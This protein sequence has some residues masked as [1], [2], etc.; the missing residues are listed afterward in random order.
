MG[1]NVKRDKSEAIKAAMAIEGLMTE[2]E[3]G[4][5]ADMLPDRPHLRVFETGAWLGRSATLWH[6]LGAQVYTIDDWSGV[7][8]VPPPFENNY[9]ERFLANVSG[10]ITPIC[11]NSNTHFDLLLTTVRLLFSVRKADLVFIDGDHS[12]EGVMHDIALAQAAANEYTVIAGHDIPMETVRRAVDENWPNGW[13]NISE[14]IWRK[15]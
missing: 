9:Q 4:I 7:G 15:R 6:A 14:M 13:D 10:A 11:A 12:Y 5:M 1:H 8:A 2:E 3:L